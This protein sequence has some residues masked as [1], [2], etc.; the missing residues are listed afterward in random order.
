MRPTI[1]FFERLRPEVVF[2]FLTL[3][4][5][6]AVLF[7]N[8]PLQAPDESD[9]FFRAFQI[10]DGT[11]V[12]EKVNGS[13]GGQLPVF[14]MQWADMEGIPFHY[15][16]K[17]TTTLFRKKLDP[18][19]VDWSKAPHDHGH[20]PHTVIYPP[21]GYAPQAATMALAK[22]A[23][24]G[25]LLLL[26]LARLS[27]FVTFA[28]LGW[29]ALRRLRIYRWSFLLLLVVPMGLY[30]MGSVAPDALLIG[31]G[32]L[33]AALVVQ[34]ASDSTHTITPRELIVLGFSM[35]L[36]AASKFI[37]FPLAL[38]TAGFAWLAFK[39]TRNRI[40][41]AALFVLVTVVP[42]YTWSRIAAHVYAPGRTDIPIDPIAQAHHM[43]AHPF[44][45]L[46]LVAQTTWGY[47]D[48]FYEWFVGMLG[49]G[50]TPL[51]RWYYRLFGAGFLVCLLLESNAARALRWPQ[52]TIL[53]AASL[54]SVLL[55]FA[56]QYVTWNQPGSSLWIDGVCGRYFLPIAPFA[57]LAVP[58]LFPWKPPASVIPLLGSLLAATGAIVCFVAVVE[59]YYA[60]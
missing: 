2:L 58:P 11:I 9:H 13:A 22:R 36:L 20:F 57:V 41:F 34:Y 3:T 15:E 42:T 45:F 43:L 54:V 25:P 24:I 52:R 51:P 60:L 39:R 8:G 37:Y 44:A 30:L 35:A 55:I 12:G 19:F 50:D 6:F 14:L 18:L 48:T 33:A 27:V 46:R 26:Y 17:V 38:A 59:R 5:G 31:S 47:G 53:A 1:S 29:S 7:A 28:C 40:L 32:F 16:K 10:S 4:F 23:H 21:L 56:A 49:W